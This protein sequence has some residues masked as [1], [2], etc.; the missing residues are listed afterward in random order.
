MLYTQTVE[1]R[2]LVL[3]KELMKDKVLD[4]FNLVGGTA[5]SLKL[6]HRMSVD[7]DLFTDRDFDSHHISHYLTEIYKAE[8]I[9]TL[10]NGIFSFIKDIKVDILAH[11]YPILNKVEEIEGIRM[12]SLQDIGAMK[13]KAILHSGTRLKDFVDMYFLLEQLPLQKIT[14]GFVQKYPDVN[15]PMAHNAL[16]YFDD[17]NKKEK[18]NFLGEGISLKQMKSRLRAAVANTSHIFKPYQGKTLLPKK[19]NSSPND[20][21]KRKYRKRPG[22]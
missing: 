3:I 9:K 8:N 5:L 2:T 13:L 20:T 1:A 6:G 11:Q 21:P 16:L 17:F 7:I 22:L 14:K 15:V 12:L 4:S 10:K 19:V 18:I